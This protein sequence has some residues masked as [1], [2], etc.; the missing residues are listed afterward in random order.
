MK[1]GKAAA[2]LLS[3]AL[4]AGSLMLP[5]EITKGADGVKGLIGP[6]KI[7]AQEGQDCD[8]NFRTWGSDNVE[9]SDLS[10]VTVSYTAYLPCAAFKKTIGESKGI[11][12]SAEFCIFSHDD[13]KDIHKEYN[14]WVKGVDMEMSEEGEVFYWFWDNEKQESEERPSYA[15]AEK[16]GDFV[17][18]SIKDAPID[19][20]RTCWSS[21]H[22]GTT[23]EDQNGEINV[24]EI[25]GG[26]YGFDLQ[27]RVNGWG[28]FEAEGEY[29]ITDVVFKCDGQE[30]YKPDYSEDRELGNWYKREVTGEENFGELKPAFLNTSF[31][32]AKEKVKA[33]PKKSVKIAANPHFEGEEVTVAID[34]KKV[35]KV[36]Y[37]NGNVVIKGAKKG[38]ATVTVTCGGIEKTIKVTVK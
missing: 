31:T 20:S 16:D 33:A 3:A 6:F 10:K 11:G 30:I 14:P 19:Y 7:V 13:E 15:S 32:V 17:K 9:I 2:G 28:G 21:I 26:V 34:K 8:Y 37:K 22:N 12:V 4:I 36:S 18:I 24:S 27:T 1:V 38:K 5:A 35:A 29:M 25:P 23:G